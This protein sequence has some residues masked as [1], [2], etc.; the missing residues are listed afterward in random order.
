MRN[1]YIKYDPYEMITEFKVNNIPVTEMD[2]RHPWLDKVFGA[3][4]MIPL[5]SWIDPVPSEKWDGLLAYLEKM[6][7]D[8]FSISFCGRKTDFEDLKESLCSQNEEKGNVLKLEFPKGKQQFIMSDSEMKAAIDEVVSIMSENRFD[9][10]VRKSENEKLKSRYDSMQTN[11]SAITNKEFRIVFTGVYSGGKS[12]VINALV[13]KNILPQAEGTCTDKIC[14]IRHSKEVAYSKVVYVMNDGQTKEELCDSGEA[15]QKR[16]RDASYIDGV[17]KVDVYVD[18]SHLYPDNLQD[19]FRLVFV[20][21]PGF[22][23]AKGDDVS[24]RGEGVTHS[25]LTKRILSSD[26]KE[27]VVF[28]S[29]SKKS[30]LSEIQK[31]L[32]IFENQ[33]GEDHGCY[34]DRFLFVLNR[35]D[36]Y[37]FHAKQKDM[38][39]GRYEGLENE[40]CKLKE[41]VSKMSHGASQRNIA[42][43]RVFPLSAATALAIKI[44]CNDAQNKPEKETE[45]RDYYDAYDNFCNKLADQHAEYFVNGPI[46]VSKV[47]DNYLLDSLSDLTKS[48]KRELQEKY[49]HA[50]NIEDYLL[51]HSG[52]L[53][54][55]TA[56]KSYI[57]KYAFPIKMR[58]LLRAFKSILQEVIE[59]N[60]SYLTDLKAAGDK[61]KQTQEEISSEKTTTDRDAV[62][63]RKLEDAESEMES[64][65][66]NVGDIEVDLSELEE[67]YTEFFRIQNVAEEYFDYEE[68]SAG[69]K[70]MVRDITNDKAEE[71]RKKISDDVENLADLAKD[72][73]S[74][75]K[76]NRW[77]VAR[78]CAQEFNRY[79]GQLENEKLL[80]V[81]SFNIQNTVAYQDIVGDG[82]F[83][84]YDCYARNIDNP[85]K[86]HIETGDGIINFFASIGRTIATAF[87]PSQINRVDAFKYKERIFVSLESN[88]R[89]LI[90]SVKTSYKSDIEYMEREMTNKMQAV[91][92]LIAKINKEIIRRNEKITK[93]IETKE[94]YRQKKK[95]LEDDCE[96]LLRLINK[97]N[98]IKQGGN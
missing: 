20:D 95:T 52:I 91:L 84:K 16:I 94:G 21:T 50:E 71:I 9:V 83:M 37:S 42:N 86:A 41:T 34:N 76:A 96:F 51:L 70:H 30:E 87:E 81:G 45:L 61:L 67:I 26:E 66:R 79:L 5:Q 63:K 25:E 59:E 3:N 31:I 97:L 90:N 77:E 46:D 33:A 1:I 64:I 78:K 23:S 18:I 89:N 44:G 58:K 29:D 36:D 35:C 47:S 17:E 68:D 85:D 88:V 13:G 27:M 4:S 82:S 60:R 72:T 48:Q 75:V 22:G 49:D 56:I 28:V 2:Y 40:V 10:M 92:D 24:V 69:E 98:V 32:D 38:T 74:K 93:D 65:L 73:V 11:I 53:S 8:T 19:Q 12:T 57:E 43:P 54:L 15:T 55:E 6:S 62:R 7:D 80:N 39:T 14:Y